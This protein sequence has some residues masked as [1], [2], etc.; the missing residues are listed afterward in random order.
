MENSKQKSNDIKL[1]YKADDFYFYSSSQTIDKSK[2]DEIQP[3]DDVLWQT[4]CHTNTSPDYFLSCYQKELCKNRDYANKILDYSSIYSGS[5]EKLLNTND[6]FNNE[7]IKMVNLG[8][9]IIGI[10]FFIYYNR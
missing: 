10:S 9:G 4:K 6:I 8:I 2:C 3:Y 7:I 5:D 1:N